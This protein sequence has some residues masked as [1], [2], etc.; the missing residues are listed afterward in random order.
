MQVQKC[1]DLKNRGNWSVGVL[2]LKSSI[3]FPLAYNLE[4]LPH[5]SQVISGK[6]SSTELESDAIKDD[7]FGEVQPW[8]KRALGKRNWPALS[9]VCQLP[10]PSKVRLK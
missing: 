4:T 7:N 9:Q 10:W 5:C 1:L 8:G 2:N 6:P 3:V